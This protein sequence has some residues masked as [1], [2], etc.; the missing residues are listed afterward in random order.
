MIW[1]EHW[2]PRSNLISKLT[3]PRLKLSSTNWKAIKWMTK[4]PRVALPLKWWWQKASRNHKSQGASQRNSRWSRGVL[5]LTEPTTART[6]ALVAIWPEDAP[7]LPPNVSMS[8][9]HYTPVA[10]AES[11]TRLEIYLKM[12]S[13]KMS[14]NHKCP[15]SNKRRKSKPASQMTKK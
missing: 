10:Y 5:T 3:D 14:K 11:V 9:H 8:M 6:C 7:N 4:I 12:T 15:L 13:L 2:C 1:R